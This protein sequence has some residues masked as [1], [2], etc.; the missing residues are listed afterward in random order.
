MD[1]ADEGEA[2]NLSEEIDEV[3][4]REAR[5]STSSSMNTPRSF[6]SSGANC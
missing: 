3:L 4:G 2:H 1:E 5:M 6:R